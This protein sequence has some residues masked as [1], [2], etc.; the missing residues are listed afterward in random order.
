[1]HKM[2]SSASTWHSAFAQRTKNQKSWKLHLFTVIFNF[3][4]RHNLKT[5]VRHRCTF[6]QYIEF[7]KILYGCII[8][9]GNY[10]KFMFK[11]SLLS[12]IMYELDIIIKIFPI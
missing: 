2:E 7:E 9:Y 10:V 3:M 5:D 4:H 1:M 11:S 8:L 12:T 6:Y